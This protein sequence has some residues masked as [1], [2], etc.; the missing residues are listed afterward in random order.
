MEDAIRRR[1]NF[2]LRRARVIALGEAATVF[3]GVAAAAMFSGTVYCHPPGATN[4]GKL[5]Y[6]HHDSARAFSA[7]SAIRIVSKKSEFDLDAI[8]MTQKH[9]TAHINLSGDSNTAFVES[10]IEIKNN[11]VIEGSSREDR[12]L[13]RFIKDGLRAMSGF[14]RG[15]RFDYSVNPSEATIG[16]RGSAA[17]EWECT[18]GNLCTRH[19]MSHPHDPVDTV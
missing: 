11:Q 9:G 2:G 15:N 4:A 19:A 6:G 1:G 14:I 5:G 3:S 18:P 13:F 7:I 8:V 12:V 17:E 16:V 10:R